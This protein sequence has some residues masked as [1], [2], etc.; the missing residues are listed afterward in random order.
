MMHSAHRNVRSHR[1]MSHVMRRARL[2]RLDKNKYGRQGGRQLD[3]LH[4]I[5][6]PTHFT[7]LLGAE[8]NKTPP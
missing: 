1:V 3:G 6:T 2:R 4:A 7:H 5:I 8:K